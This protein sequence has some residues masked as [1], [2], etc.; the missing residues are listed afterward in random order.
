M[1]LRLT[2]LFAWYDIWVGVFIDTAKRAVYVFPI[3]MVGIKFQL[4]DKIRERRQP[5]PTGRH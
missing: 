1:K 3:P 2:V 4:V 5:T